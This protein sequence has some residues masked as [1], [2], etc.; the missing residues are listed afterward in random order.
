MTIYIKL[1]MIMISEVCHIQRASYQ[2]H[3][4]RLIIF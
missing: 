3:N 1:V 2:G 4:H